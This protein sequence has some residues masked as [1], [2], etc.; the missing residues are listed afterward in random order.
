MHRGDRFEKSLDSILENTTGE[1]EIGNWLGLRQDSIVLSESTSREVF[2]TLDPADG[3]G[4]S[5]HTRLNEDTRAAS[6][7]S[8]IP[9]RTNGM[10]VTIH[11]L[12]LY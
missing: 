11:A 9:L 12:L 1:E 7:N 6:E 8:A 2:K 10:C 5:M 4:D 3:G